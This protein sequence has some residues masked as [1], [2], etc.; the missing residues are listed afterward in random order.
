MREN[1]IKRLRMLLETDV[2]EA[3]AIVAAKGFSGQLQQML[4]KVGRLQNEDLPPASDKMRDTYG[5]PPAQEFQTTTYASLQAIIDAI[6]AAKDT[7]DQNVVKMSQGN[8]MNDMDQ[9][10]GEMDASI[11]VDPLAGEMD[12]ELEVDPGL[13]PEMGD[14][15]AGDPE[16]DAELA[17]IED[18]FGGD[19]S[20]AG[21]E[22]EPLGRAK[23]ES[24][25]SIGR[26][27]QEMQ[28]RITKLKKSKLREK[29]TA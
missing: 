22:D 14:E 8:F 1:Y 7:L 27:I 28:D 29:R 6:Y 4:E 16:L 25:Q 20:M 18:E 17:G 15:L 3:E 5:I 9:M 2:D 24:V 10:G 23:K 21:P 26:K 19:E 11:D 12:A 13:D